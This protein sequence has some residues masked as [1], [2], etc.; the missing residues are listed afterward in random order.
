[1]DVTSEI[2]RHR[3]RHRPPGLFKGWDS[4]FCVLGQFNMTNDY[5][6]RKKR[7]RNPPPNTVA[8]GEVE[9][10][11]GKKERPKRAKVRR[12]CRGH[13]FQEPAVKD[14]DKSWPQ[15][16]MVEGAQTRGTRRSELPI[17]VPVSLITV[18]D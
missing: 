10:L 18:G 14:E 2:P 7:K 3:L 6:A 16:E 4:L 15:E 11:G 13:C 5:A 1:M 9:S 17:V 12:L 8:F